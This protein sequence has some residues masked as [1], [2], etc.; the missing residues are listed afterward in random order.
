[1][2]EIERTERKLQRESRCDEHTRRKHVARKPTVHRTL[3]LI[4]VHRIYHSILF[5]MQM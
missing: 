5:S 3:F 1:M 4:V 2:T